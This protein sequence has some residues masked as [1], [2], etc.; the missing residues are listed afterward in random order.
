MD[1]CAD[2]TVPH[3]STTG[4]EASDSKS[5]GTISNNDG[6]GTSSG[7]DTIIGLSD[8]VVNLGTQGDYNMISDADWMPENEEQVAL[9]QHKPIAQRTKKPIS[10]TTPAHKHTFII[11]INS[12]LAI[13]TPE[14]FKEAMSLPH[15]ADWLHA[16]H[17]EYKLII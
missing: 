15:S 8:Q 4:S 6:G 7:G 12:S 1:H 11:Y 5:E 17:K 14:S 16:V 3:N 10:Y 2:N 9:H 13:I